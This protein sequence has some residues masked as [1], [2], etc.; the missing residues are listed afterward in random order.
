MLVVLMT[1]K[2]LKLIKL[3]N[4]KMVYITSIAKGLLAHCRRNRKKYFTDL[5]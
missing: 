2:I 4:E 1:I 3:S 5:N